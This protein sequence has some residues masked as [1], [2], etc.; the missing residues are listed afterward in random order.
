M[1]VMIHQVDPTYAMLTYRVERQ[2][3]N[4]LGGLRKHIN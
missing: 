2:A 3:D 4:L 1:N